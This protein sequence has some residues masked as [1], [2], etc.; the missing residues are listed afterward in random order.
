MIFHAVFGTVH[1]M[2]L[3]QFL[4]PILEPQALA[5][6]ALSQDWH[7]RSMYMF[8]LFPLL[9]KGIQKLR[10]TEESKVILIA[11][12]GRHNHGFRIF[13]IYFV[14]V[15]ATLSSFCTLPGPTVTTGVYLGWQ[16]IQSA[17]MEAL[18]QQDFQKRSLDSRKLL[19]GPLHTECMTTAGFPLL[20]GPQ[21]K[22]LIHLV[23]QLLK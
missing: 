1:N 9:G 7:R 3:L 19:E 21:D 20:T 6:D 14:C 5:I 12:G 18:K 8:P 2:H 4:S 11:P 10:T 16:V 22:E 23:T 17:C 15:W 13:I